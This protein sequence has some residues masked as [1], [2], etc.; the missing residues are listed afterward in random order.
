MQLINVLVVSI[1][2]GWYNLI[3]KHKN[4]YMKYYWTKGRKRQRKQVFI[5]LGAII[6]ATITIGA[7][8]VYTERY[9]L[10]VGETNQSYKFIEPEPALSVEQQIRNIAE[11]EGF[12]WADYLVRLANCESRLDPLAEN[13][14][15]NY[16]S[17][18]TDRGL[19]QINNYWHYEVSDKQAFDLEYATVWT[20]E[21][22]NAG[23]QHEWACNSIVLN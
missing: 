20:I 7:N 12:R 13:R 3:H 21:R 5:L 19:F 23:Y 22:I 9:I 15:G 10:K 8:Q 14:Q 6:L 2:I 17:N 11:R 1:I 16:P 18:S 4:K